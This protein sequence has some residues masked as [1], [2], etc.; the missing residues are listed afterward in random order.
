MISF[1]LPRR[2]P[3]PAG[4]TGVD[5]SRGEASPARIALDARTRQ[6]A[7]D[8][9]PV[10]I[11]ARAFDILHMLVE[12]RDR[13][14]LKSELLERVWPGVFV[15]ENNLQVHVSALRKVLGRNAVAT[16]PGRGYRFTAVAQAVDVASAAREPVAHSSADQVSIAVL[17]FATTG[18]GAGERDF[19]EGLG[20]GIVTGLSRW[21]S[22]A[23]LSRG[24]AARFEGQAANALTIGRELGVCYLVDGSVRSRGGQVRVSAQLIDVDSETQLWG[25]RFDRPLADGLAAQD[26]IVQ[27]IVGRV[28]G[29][30]H[31]SGAE[32]VRRMPAE[33]LDA[34]ELTLRG[35]ALRWDDAAGRGEARQAFEQAIGIDPGYALPRSLLAAL[36]VRDWESGEPGARQ[37]LDRAF[38][39]AQRAVELAD[40][41]S[42][43]HSI[44]GGVAWERGAYDLALHHADLGVRLNPA[45]QWNRA[46]LGA[47]LAYAG[48]AEEGRALL[49][50]ARCADPYFG[51]PW[52]WRGLGVA[53]FVLRRYDDA[54]ADFER[55]AADRSLRASA[56]MAACCAMLGFGTRAREC[57]DRCKAV[58]PAASVSLLVERTPFRLADDMRHFA[59]ALRAAG[60]PE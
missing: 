48:R 5:R 50:D 55:G 17:P 22:L 4:G 3:L 7:I 59:D 14:V 58:Q 21:R 6:L 30:L 2:S 20:E 46:D 40:D 45:N 12:H 43:C 60:M 10:R 44:L 57:I 19:A 53:A 25:E 35:N 47:L 27:A 33:G 34:Y 24:A 18:T 9:K 29:R 51:P 37:L 42:T 38:E 39:L 36:L 26:E 15:E 8:G 41:D 11:G 54:L 56:M 31:A 49:Q 13:V 16:V 1:D 28:V 52:Y 32:R 23:V